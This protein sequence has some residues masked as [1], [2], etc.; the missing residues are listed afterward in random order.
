MN[1]IW[2][3]IRDIAKDIAE[4]MTVIWATLIIGALFIFGPVVVVYYG[5]KLM[6]FL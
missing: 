3:T 5:M 1:R 4:D 2:W 6:G